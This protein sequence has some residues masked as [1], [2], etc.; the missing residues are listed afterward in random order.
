VQST[1]GRRTGAERRSSA[2]SAAAIWKSRHG[3]SRARRSQKRSTTVQKNEPRSSWRKWCGGPLSCLRV[4]G[5]RAAAGGTWDP[6]KET[7]TDSGGADDA[8]SLRSDALASGASGLTDAM[9]L[10]QGI[11]RRRTAVP[12]PRVRLGKCICTHRYT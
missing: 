6:D 9:G 1:E 10:L 3:S 8:R 12:R 2:G 11:D 7:G 5:C 4:V